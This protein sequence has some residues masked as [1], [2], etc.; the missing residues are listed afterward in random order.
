MVKGIE[1][2]LFVA[3][4]RETIEEYVALGRVKTPPMPIPPEMETCAGA[5]VTIHKHGRLRG[6][7]GTIEP[8]QPNLAM[9]VIHNAISASTQD[10]RFEPITE[11]ELENLTISVDV[12]SHPEL[13]T[14]FDE[15]DPRQYGVIVESG[16]RRGLLLPD[17]DGV[18][19]V[20][21]QVGIA[22]QK[23]GIRSG[24]PIQ[25][26]RFQVTRHGGH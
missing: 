6:C 9:E 5:F 12:L 26:Y 23:A 11:D 21:E 8:C 16:W 7:I 20:D 4:A 24:E 25:L 10:P 14:A 13:V 19:T 3:L 15:L 1:G 22:M 2:D 18:D 17:L